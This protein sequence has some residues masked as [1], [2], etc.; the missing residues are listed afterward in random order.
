MNLP[1]RAVE[2]L[3]KVTVEFCGQG[4][5]MEP[6]RLEWIVGLGVEGLTPFENSLL[7]KQAGEEIEIRTKDVDTACAFGP[8]AC[9]IAP[10]ASAPD[11]VIV[12]RVVGVTPAESR[13]VVKGLAE[14]AACGGGC[15]CCGH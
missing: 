12:A 15:D 8:L 6:G 3:S 2:N 5:G 13:E 9:R 14:R 10:F 1:G 7:G 4:S 11:G